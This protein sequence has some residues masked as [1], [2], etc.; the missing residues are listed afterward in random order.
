MSTKVVAAR[1]AT[2][3]GVTTIITRSSQPGNI[4]NIVTYL[5]ELKHQNHSNS[6]SSTLSTSPP[7]L[8]TRFLPNPFPIRD[9]SFWLLHGLRPN[10]TIYIDQG[11]Y[12]ALINKAGLLAVGIIEVEGEFAQQEAVHL[13]VGIRDAF[14]P[15]SFSSEA[16]GGVG[17]GRKKGPAEQEKK[18]VGRAVVNYSSTEIIRIKGLQ[19]TEII[20]ILG[21]A[22]SEYVA[23]RH[24][25][26]LFPP[27]GVTTP[28]ASSLSSSTVLAG[29][30]VGATSNNSLSS[31]GG[32]D[33]FES[34]EDRYLP[35]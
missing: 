9:R 31:V 2:S 28:T 26:S 19:S 34:K 11:A 6:T 29:A 30:G 22:D 3:V 20:N 10:G 24:N 16:G 33:G 23:D 13:V 7:P 1:L 27:A 21:Y 32:G 15:S 35:T 12:Q 14:S 25:I 17:G 8:H 18:K 4:F 5:Q